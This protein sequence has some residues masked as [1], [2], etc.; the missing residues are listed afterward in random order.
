MTLA[1]TLMRLPDQVERLLTVTGRPGPPHHR[2]GPHINEEEEGVRATACR[3]IVR[4][5]NL[6]H[7]SCLLR[8]GDKSKGSSGNTL[9]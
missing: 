5:H 7:I 3:H 6:N 8:N 2:S 1:P 9:W 4:L